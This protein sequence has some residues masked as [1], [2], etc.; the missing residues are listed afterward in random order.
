MPRGH[1]Y[2]WG[3][4]FEK[5]DETIAQS[6]WG[7]YIIARDSIG[8]PAGHEVSFWSEAIESPLGSLQNDNER[9]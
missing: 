8:H 7:S 1:H 9:G 3:A 2:A 6:L 4:T 5:V